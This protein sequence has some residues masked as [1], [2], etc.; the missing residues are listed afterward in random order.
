MRLADFILANVEPILEEWERFA[1]GL[2]PGSEMSILAL[3]DHAEDLLRVTA[4]DMT[5]SQSSQQQ[6]DKSKGW[7]GGG[8]ESGGLDRASAD[9]A[10]ER[11]GAGFN[12]NEVVSEYRALR[13]SVLRLWKESVHEGDERDL[14]DLT[15]FNESIDQSLGEAVRSF[16]NRVE[17]SRELF[18][19]TLGHDLRAP[20]NAIMLSSQLLARSGQ[21][22]DENAQTASQMVNF[23]KVMTGMIN[24]LLDFT[25]ARL[26]GGM[27]VSTESVDLAP[28]CREVIDE[29]RVAH[30]DR[31][32]RLECP[33][34]VSG[35]WDAARLRQVISN[36][37]ANAIMHGEEGTPVE[38]SVNVDGPDVLL[39]VANRGPA[40]PP[41]ALP[42]L[43]DPFVRA[44][45]GASGKGAAFGG[46]GLGLYIVRQIVVSHRG[47]ISVASS[48]ATGTVVTVRLPRRPRPE[49]RPKTRD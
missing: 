3:R 25:R 27:P 44:A 5:S 10:I 47:T 8:T 31:T 26:G 43:F 7:G 20:L 21:L 13:A 11:L 48:D 40:I 23:G 39:A 32:V 30:P 35:E 22:D 15:R 18:L 41:A 36:L 38:V 49:P 1:R 37:V 28:L 14:E 16:T 19:A 42:T 17:E 4:R 2:A 6:S 34:G 45:S 33:G 9:H 24:D 46:I 29:F 12:L